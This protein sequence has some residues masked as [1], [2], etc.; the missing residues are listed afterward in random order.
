MDAAHTASEFIERL[1]EGPLLADGA[2]GTQL[3]A[4][5]VSF[6]RCF[7]ALNL[8]DP[9]LVTRVHEAYVASG[10]RMIETN[11][12]GANSV[13]LAEHGLAERAA[14]IA[15]AGARIARDTADAFAAANE[16]QAVWVA[17]SV[18]PLGVPI[19]PVGALGRDEARAVFGVQI[20]AL[21]E[22]G[23]DLI[24][25]ETMVD[26]G[27]AQL[28]LA[29]ARDTT[30]L[31]VCVFMTFGSD[32]RTPGGATPEEIVAALEAD[33]ADVI[34][35]NCSTGPA[36]MLD[37]LA[38]MADVATVPLAAMPNAGLPTLVSGRYIYASSPAYMADRSARMV[39]AGVSLIGGCCGTGPAHISAIAGA[40]DGAR[41]EPPR[42][43][44]PF[45]GAASDAEGQGVPA[46][47]RGPTPLQDILAERFAL[48]VQVEPPRGFNIS[49]LLP[50]LKRLSEAGAVD[51][52]CLTDAAGARARVSALAL[53][54]V[55]R[56]EVGV[57][58]VLQMGCAYR[59]LVATHSELLGAHALGARDILVVGGDLP[60][61]GDYPDATV[62]RDLTDV[63]L[64]RMID[65]FNRGYDP[66][67]RALEEI[68]AFHVG[69]DFDPSAR[70]LDRARAEL[71]DKVAAGANFVVTRPVFGVSELVR[72]R[73]AFGGSFPVPVIASVLPLWDARHARYLHNEVPDLDIPDDVMDRMSA[74][75][76]TRQ[77]GV[78]IAA[79]TVTALRDVVGGVLLIPPF[80]HLEHVE[81]VIEA[82]S[83]RRAQV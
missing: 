67:G 39:D 36:P 72:A 46:E 76:D 50:G 25:I 30:D 2:M 53:G 81:A 26:L 18:G 75:D 57:P 24:V 16:G 28:A 15:E 32:G 73:D 43:S 78:Q 5:G 52:L 64:I 74:A 83:E 61:N 51:A 3:Y 19:A 82:I 27:E 58:T 34:G 65:G 11:T 55:V 70:D 80:G 66:Q 12:F 45:L 31:P 6:D 41:R 22:G 8:S 54:A 10:A 42:P 21:A 33:G 69:C 9:D 13:R 62:V 56:G 77:V 14:E 44:F 35:A 37:V 59:N 29:A 49:P 47:L 48:I 1:N 7:D 63:G 79:E 23:A 71:E 40:L 38:R 68:T 17:G 20:A 60:A 4:H